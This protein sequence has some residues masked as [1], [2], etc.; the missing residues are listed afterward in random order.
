MD[1]EGTV[2]TRRLRDGL[3]L[4]SVITQAFADPATD[5]RQALGTVVQRLAT[6]I[7]DTCC[8]M[9]RDGDLLRV[10]ALHEPP[11]EHGPHAVDRP[12]LIED[13]PIPAGVLAGGPVFMPA[14]DFDA[15]GRK[16]APAV[17]A[18]L[19]A[20]DATGLLVVPLAIRGDQLGA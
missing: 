1:D 6:S 20:G 2:Q 15:L 8:V 5:V 13:A 9:L 4:I 14:I 7:P 16:L 18:R 3:R 10:A 11:D 12:R 19:R 17:I